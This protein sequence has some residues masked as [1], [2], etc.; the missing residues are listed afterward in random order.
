LLSFSTSKSSSSSSSS[1]SSEEAYKA[2]LQQEAIKEEN[3]ARS[4]E[5]KHKP[6]S[7]DKST[8]ERKEE[9]KPKKNPIVFLELEGR[10]KE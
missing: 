4:A 9:K 3:L 7:N 8:R 6:K 10:A 1:S 2:Y 5:L